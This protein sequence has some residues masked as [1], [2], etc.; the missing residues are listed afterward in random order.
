MSRYSTYS[1]IP[2]MQQ[3]IANSIVNADN[4]PN[5]RLRASFNVSLRVNDSVSTG[6]IPVNLIGPG[7]VI[8][9]NPRAI[10]RAEPQN[11][12]TDFEPN[13]L[14]F[15]EFYEEDFPWRYTPAKG[16]DNNYRLRPWIALVVLAE[17]EFEDLASLQGPLEGIRI[18]DKNGADLFPVAGDLWA[19]AHVHVNED[20]S[21]GGNS[22]AENAVSSL[23]SLLVSDPDIAYSRLLCPR[24]LKPDTPYHAFLIP[25]FETGRLAGLGLDIDPDT[26]ATRSAWDG[27]Q[28]MFPYY[29]RWHF[30]TAVVGDFEFHVRQLRPGPVDDRVG[31]RDMDVSNPGSNID[32]I[33]QGIIGLE[34]ALR[35][36]QT[37][38]TNW[39][40]TFPD[41]FQAGMVNRINLAY[42]YQQSVPGSDPVVT[43]PLYARWHAL[44]QRLT[45]PLS[46]NINWVHELN[47]DPR[48]RV[49]AGFGAD[50][51]RRNQE[52]YMDSAWNQIGRV[53]EAN[54]KIKWVQ[55]AR[56]ASV[57]LFEKFIEPLNNAKLISFSS[58]V[59]KKVLSANKTVFNLV[60]TSRIEFV[61]VSAAFRKV[62]RKR[63]K[64]STR[65]QAVSPFDHSGIIEAVNSGEIT[66]AKPK[67]V[68][69]G[70]ANNREVTGNV[71]P[72]DVPAIILRWLKSW[73]LVRW[74]AYLPLFILILAL[75]FAIVFPGLIGGWTW[76][77]AVLLVLAIIAAFFIKWHQSIKKYQIPQEEDRTSGQIDR[78]P[79][80]TNFSIS[81][82]GE[83]VT[84][85]KGGFDNAASVAFKDALKDLHSMYERSPGSPDIKPALDVASV[86]HD[87]VYNIHPDYAVNLRAGSILM[88]PEHMIYRRG[89]RIVPVMAYPEFDIPMYQPLRDISSE[90]LIP[91][92][93]L[94][95]QNTVTLLETNQK[96]I[97]SYMVGLNH[98]MS[99]E[100][101]WRE[102]ITDQRGSYFRQFWDVSNYVNMDDSLSDEDLKEKLKDIKPI[103]TWPGSGKLG[104]NNNR[105]RGGD[106]SQLVLAIRGELLK[107]YPNT[108]IYAQRARWKMKTE[109]GKQVI[110]RYSPRELVEVD[111]GS[112]NDLKFPLYGAKIDPDITFLGFDLNAGD[113][114]GGTGEGDDDD[115]G[116]FFV[117]EERVGE[118]RFGLDIAAE[119][120]ST[121]E[122]TTWNDLTWNHIST[123]T[124]DNILLSS[125]ITID[126][127]ENNPERI[128]WGK[129]SNAADMASI[130]FQLPVRVGMHG[131]EL[132][133]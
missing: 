97:E 91:N 102:F 104:M 74:K 16:D 60:K 63:G 2:W 58:N 47:A 68:P 32:G 110:D 35:A 44:T 77:S 114:K 5:A 51:V 31:I 6:N 89:D 49:P 55:F 124:S 133:V 34:G 10:V 21:D 100:L 76:F 107:K 42:D 87:L 122:L 22:S 20:L 33:D 119:E 112:V 96:F 26:M 18:K 67:E 8:G 130:L 113:V 121:P 92:L 11:L 36:P 81:R 88:V 24:K 78:L 41:Q 7:D 71:K 27:A 12:I 15:V 82:P 13:F 25:A 85:E 93:N 23:N 45:V 109:N 9:I 38:S 4:D 56:L 128:R 48:S 118:P 123:N 84:L 79:N 86:S 120:G 43:P 64:I 75:I 116:W 132:L 90:L 59:S 108:V 127:L 129:D 62:F 28:N 66:A 53:L 99:R 73:L 98:E 30:R 1:F 19:W 50:V 94:I 117:I 83:K 3:G 101:L 105:E 57:R 95:P 80:F 70:S 40:V 65:L 125:S 115:P 17:D 52:E 46:E 54:A 39:P 61:P 37:S 72:K 69:K 106:S 29:Y 126:S 131:A 111:E 103:H 14:P